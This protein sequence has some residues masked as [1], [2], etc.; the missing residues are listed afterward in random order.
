MKSTLAICIGALFLNACGGHL[1]NDNCN[2]A[3][4]TYAD[5]VGTS[6][7]TL[8]PSQHMFIPFS[9]MEQIYREVEICTGISA[10]GP[11]VEYR[12]FSFYN[13]GGV[14]AVTTLG[15]ALKDYIL[16]NTDTDQFL[17]RSCKSDASALRHEFVHY[18]LD[19]AG[20]EYISTG[21]NQSHNS[22]KF[23]QCGAGVATS[24]GVPI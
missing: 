20:K 22:P 19:Q 14:W 4:N 18:L 16:V 24:N 10:P 12:S 8:K 11:T 6:G 2:V 5:T 23:G 15:Q 17:Q 3:I 7:L 13:I 9:Q 21:D 1:P